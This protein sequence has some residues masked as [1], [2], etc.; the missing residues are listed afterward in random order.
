MHFLLFFFSLP[1]AVMLA[2]VTLILVR[3]RITLIPAILFLAYIA[4]SIFQ[5]AR[6]PGNALLDTLP[7]LLIAVG[8]LCMYKGRQQLLLVPAGA[9]TD[10]IA[11]AAL[12]GPTPPSWTWL[13][14]F[15]EALVIGMFTFNSI[16]FAKSPLVLGVLAVFSCL[17]A[18]WFRGQL[19]NYVIV[20]V[21]EGFAA[22]FVALA[23]PVME[24]ILEAVLNE[25]LKKVG[26]KVRAHHRQL[27]AYYAAKMLEKH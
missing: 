22:L 8:L 20:L 12:S 23:F 18:L 19:W 9:T 25:K 6:L 11:K 3:F 26:D 24:L 16:S 21:L 2:G 1:T 27:E 17:A 15:G 4:F 13:F 5:R 14:F 7:P 10:A